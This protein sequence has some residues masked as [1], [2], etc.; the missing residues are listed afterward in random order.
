[1]CIA[2]EH[3]PYLPF[4]S[5]LQSFSCLKYIY[6]KSK[7]IFTRISLRMASHMSKSC[8]LRTI[9]VFQCTASIYPLQKM[10]L[11]ATLEVCASFRNRQKPQHKTFKGKWFNMNLFP[12]AYWFEW[13]SMF[14]CLKR[15]IKEH[16]FLGWYRVPCVLQMSSKIIKS[17]LH[18]YFFR[19]KTRP[20]DF[21]P[22]CNIV[23]A[24]GGSG[25]LMTFKNM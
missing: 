11:A 5:F 17:P 2:S 12:L 3:R 13:S 14:A 18:M 19:H 20:I 6:D 25:F 16:I 10:I 4:L 8:K 15:E 9:C 23:T 24:N 21:E 22:V 1:M 7:K